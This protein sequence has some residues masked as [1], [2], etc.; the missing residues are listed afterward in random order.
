MPVRGKPMG[1]PAEGPTPLGLDELPIPTAKA[2]TPSRD[3]RVSEMLAEL[4]ASK[5][6]VEREAERERELVRAD[7]V[8]QLLPVLD[9][10]D[11][12]IEASGQST[13]E[14]L[15]EGVKMV[16]NQFEEVLQ[17]FGMEVL[18]ARGAPFDPAEHEAVAMV[19]VETPQAHRTVVSVV[20]PG[21]RMGGRLLRAA[22]V[23]VGDHREPEVD[24]G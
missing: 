4:E 22:Q 1:T 12:S 18:D 14:P 9:N 20:R 21:Y 11:R 17:G 23:T 7:L 16:R 6:R 24:G 5:K 10:L 19:P 15:R 2:V 3:A 8:R 13:D